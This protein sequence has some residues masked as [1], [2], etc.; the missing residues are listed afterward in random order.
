MF[1]P[2]FEVNIS[3]PEARERCTVASRRP[4]TFAMLTTL[5]AASAL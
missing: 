3:A 4:L 5:G 1:F 2:H